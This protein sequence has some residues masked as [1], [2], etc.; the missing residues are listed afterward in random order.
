MELQ[1]ELAQ[2]A[3]QMS[4]EVVEISPLT[5]DQLDKKLTE[6][7]ELDD[8]YKELKGELTALGDLVD[9][10]KYEMLNILEALDRQ[11]YTLPGVGMASKVTEKR[12][13]MPEDTTQREAIFKY[14]ADTYGKEALYGYTTIHATKFNSFVN[15]ELATGKT[16]PGVGAPTVDTYVKF[17]RR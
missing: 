8:K 4:E 9:A 5:V 13:K 14:I 6:L 11:N 15:E 16:V 12:F 3:L 10:K 1:S 7:R 2:A 17:L